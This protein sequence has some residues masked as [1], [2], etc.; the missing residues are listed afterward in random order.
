MKIKFFL[1]PLFMFLFTCGEKMWEDEPFS[2][3]VNGKRFIPVGSSD[4]KA[5]SAVSV[6]LIGGKHFWISAKSGQKSLIF[7]VLDTVNGIKVGDY[8]LSEKQGNKGEYSSDR[9]S[10]T[11][12]STDINHTG[13]LSITKIDKVKETVTGKFY[14]KALNSANGD[15]VDVTNGRFDSR[16]AKY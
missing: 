7:G 1:F 12:F 15:V 6:H 9:F 5:P 10:T 4:F 11:I 2:V 8:V 3:K 16:Y 13:L 14:Y